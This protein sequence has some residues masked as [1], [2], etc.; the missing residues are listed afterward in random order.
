M[1]FYFKHN[2]QQEP[3]AFWLTRECLE[4][5]TADE[6]EESPSNAGFVAALAGVIFI[7][8]AVRVVVWLFCGC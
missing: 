1:F 2:K 7:F 4:T 3:F 5:E 6:Q 8:A